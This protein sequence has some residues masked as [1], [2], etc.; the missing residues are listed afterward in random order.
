MKYH[1]HIFCGGDCERKKMKKVVDLFGYYRK[2]HYICSSERDDEKKV[3]K[4]VEKI[5][6]IQKKVLY[7]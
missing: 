6:N 1:R 4:K 3:V 7:L 5:W 2:N